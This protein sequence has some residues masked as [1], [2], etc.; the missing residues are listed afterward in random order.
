V[1]QSEL[2][3]LFT[4]NALGTISKQ[5]KIEKFGIVLTLPGKGNKKGNIP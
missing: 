3:A 2:L 4:S 5:V 1:G